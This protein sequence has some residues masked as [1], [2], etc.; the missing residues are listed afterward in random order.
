MKNTLFDRRRT[1][2]CA[3]LVASMLATGACDRGA[4]NHANTAAATTDT[5]AA[6]AGPIVVTIV[7]DE[8]K[9]T[10]PDTIFAG[11]TTVR[12]DNHGREPHEAAL[13]RLDSGKTG[14]DLLAIAGSTTPAPNPAWMHWVGGPTASLPGGTA[15]V[16]AVTL[17]PGHYVVLCAIPGPGGHPHFSLGMVK[18]FTVY[19]SSRALPAPASDVAITLSDYDFQFAAPLT[20]GA[21][22]L[23]VT[24]TSRQNHQ[25]VVFR[26]A[27]GKSVD[28][29]LAWVRDM[30]GAPPFVW[31]TGTTDL[32]T[33][34]T[35]FVEATFAPGEYALLCF[36]SDD[37][38]G[39]PHFVHG[40]KKQFTVT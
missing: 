17:T 29:I 10:L 6:P 40:M 18:D 13:V 12:L 36:D 24:N 7:G 26:L 16:V 23:R 25:M 21:H 8:Y 15:P 39:K 3:A 9:F 20:S 33:G 22:T 37:R 5:S 31:A 38:D 2:T 32:S 14:T 4:A 27:P 35:S 34:A 11:V 28:D 19:P 1:L 30:K